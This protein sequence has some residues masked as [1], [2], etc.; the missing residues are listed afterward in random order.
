MGSFVSTLL[1]LSSTIFL[2]CGPRTIEC[3]VIP[4]CSLTPLPPYHRNYHSIQY[5]VMELPFRIFKFFYHVDNLTI[6]Q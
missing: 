1:G 4:F 6:A 3:Y 2:V 5:I